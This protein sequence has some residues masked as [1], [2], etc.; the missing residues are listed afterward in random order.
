MNS[1]YIVWVSRQYIPIVVEVKVGLEMKSKKRWIWIRQPQTN[2]VSKLPC[3]PYGTSLIRWTLR[4]LPASMIY[5]SS[6]LL[7]LATSV[8]IWFGAMVPF[9]LYRLSFLMTWHVIH[10]KKSYLRLKL[11]HLTKVCWIFVFSFMIVLLFDS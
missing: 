4:C 1:C 2:L 3:R 9:F 11:F 5:L 7:F 8:T 10:E 6:S